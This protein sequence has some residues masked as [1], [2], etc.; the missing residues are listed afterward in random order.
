MCCG[1]D[2]HFFHGVYVPT[3]I[4]QRKLEPSPSPFVKVHWEGSKLLG[5]LYADKPALSMGM[6]SLHCSS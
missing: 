4:L 2:F 5:G 1:R 6:W 3:G